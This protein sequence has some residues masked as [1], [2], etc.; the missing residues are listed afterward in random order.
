[1]KLRT[2]AFRNI[3]RNRRRSILSGTAIAVAA[4][5][6]VLLFSFIAGMIDDMEYNFHTYTTGAVRI[7]HK[8]FTRYERLN[9]MHLTVDVSDGIMGK[10]TNEEGVALVSPRISFPTRIYRDGE[11]YNA[12][13]TGIDFSTETAYQDLGPDVVVKGRIPREG[14]N[15]ILIGYKLAEEVGVSLDDKI[16]ILSSTAARG[17]NA[18]T[19]TIVGVLA[20]PMGGLNSTTILAPLD[21]VQYFLRMPDQVQEILMKVDEGVDSTALAQ[22]LRE[23]YGD[24]YGVEIM[25][26]KEMDT[27]Y[28]FIEMAQTIYDIVALF[29]FVLGS[30]V[31]LNTTIMVIFERMREI[32]TMS[33]MGMSGKDL[34]R[35]FFL[36]AFIIGAAGSLVG[37]LM[38]IG[39]TQILAQVGLDFGE[40]MEGVDFEI[41]T[42]LYPKLN[43]KSTVVVF[44]YSVI[45]A[46]LTS[47]LP[48][49]RASRIE[50]V[51]ALRAI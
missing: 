41:S 37:V 43:L 35:L 33:A 29:F 5:S 3:F 34:V 46:S 27:S 31:I 1:M 14:E 26:W 9:P 19:F 38:G 47:I 13:G 24:E 21:R 10:I 45:V 2:I 25:G 39:F 23:K 18:I 30:S 7:R 17:T 49:R 40:A 6:I 44:F 50:P 22:R 32:G 36:E 51:D 16:T 8:D 20:Y 4:M 48:A 28:S 12:F 15:E 42:I 11:N